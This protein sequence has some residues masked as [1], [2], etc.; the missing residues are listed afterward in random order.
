MSTLKDA[1]KVAPI[2][3]QATFSL[4]HLPKKYHKGAKAYLARGV[5]PVGFLQAA[6]ENDLVNTCDQCFMEE[7]DNIWKTARWLYREM[8]PGTWGSEKRV[9]DYMRERRRQPYEN[10]KWIT[11]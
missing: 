11:E 10:V 9:L 1:I 4:K 2:T 8:W 5:Q 6:L 3:D 7:K